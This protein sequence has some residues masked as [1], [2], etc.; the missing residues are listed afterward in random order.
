MC[1]INPAVTG[2]ARIIT[3]AVPGLPEHSIIPAVTGPAPVITPA[4]FTTYIN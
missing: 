4:A 1:R 3:P 2:P